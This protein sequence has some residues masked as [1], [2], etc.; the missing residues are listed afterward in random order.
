[1]IS[2]MPAAPVCTAAEV[3][4]V[5]APE[6]VVATLT[7]VEVSRVEVLGLLVE[8]VEL[9]AEGAELETTTTAEVELVTGTGM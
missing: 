1:M 3:E 2:M 7:G 9:L 4:A 5:A 8:T 6:V